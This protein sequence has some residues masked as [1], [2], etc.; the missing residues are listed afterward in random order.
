MANQPP[1]PDLN[2]DDDDV[3]RESSRGGNEPPPEKNDTPEQNVGY[4]EAVKGRRLTPEERRKAE[5]ESPL[6]EE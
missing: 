1:T 4:D 3:I 5:R 2:D 6:S